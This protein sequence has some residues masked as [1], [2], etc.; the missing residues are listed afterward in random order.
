MTEQ[1]IKE[2]PTSECSC[3]LCQSCCVSSPCFGTP[4]DIM[5][6]VNKGY[7][8]KLFPTIWVN[9][10]N[11]NVHQTIAPKAR[12]DGSCIFFNNGLCDIHSLKPVEGKIINH[13][14]SF[15]Q[16]AAAR[17]A[18]L[19]TWENHDAQSFFHYFSNSIK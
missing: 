13:K 2:L 17:L 1:M 8:D 14:F 3:E 12:A 19:Q 10:F 4:S 15:Q 16:T 18:T 6:L 11:K 9:P 5:N 7:K